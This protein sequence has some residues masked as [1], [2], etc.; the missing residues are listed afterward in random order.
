M[1]ENKKWYFL[2]FK[3]NY[4]QQDNIIA[5]E[6]LENGYIYSLI[7]LKLHLKSLKHDG[8][9]KMTDTIPYNTSMIPMIA[10]AIHH[11]ADHVEKAI[12]RSMEL[13]IITISEAGEIF[14]DDIHTLIGKTSSEAERLKIH[15]E[16]IKNSD[17]SR[18]ALKKVYERTP[19]LEL[20]IELEN[21][22]IDEKKPTNNTFCKDLITLWNDN[23]HEFYRVKPDDKEVYKCLNKKR[24]TMR[25]DDLLKAVKL[26]IE[27]QKDD[28][29]YYTTEYD[30]IEFIYK[31]ALY[32]QDIEKIKHKFSK[33]KK[34]SDT[35]MP[36]YDF[37]LKHNILV[38]EVKTA[39][40]KTEKYVNTERDRFAPPQWSPYKP[41]TTREEYIKLIEIANGIKITDEKR[42]LI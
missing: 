17:N 32:Y 7:V 5:L 8:Q 38:K 1:S 4:F 35:S 39:T 42:K 11:D 40:G 13:G 3:E 6:S 9:L 10:K 16:R 24:K 30:F 12:K 25:D 23:I 31:K 34:T 36:L 27:L 33:D 14:M 21:R 20:E 15:R 29:Y 2:K 28:K 37:Y 18:K 26:H 41:P 22:D 19:E